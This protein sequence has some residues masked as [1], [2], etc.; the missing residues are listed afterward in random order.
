MESHIEHGYREIER[1]H[2]DFF[3]STHTRLEQYVIYGKA[4]NK[5]EPIK[6][7]VIISKELPEEIR[8]EV[9]WLYKPILEVTAA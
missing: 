3:K 1:R 2:A 9:E 4:S 5:F 7:E 6:L 8:K